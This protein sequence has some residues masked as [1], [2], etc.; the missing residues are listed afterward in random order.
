[1]E[2]SALNSQEFIDSFVAIEMHL[3]TLVGGSY[4]P[5]HQ[6]VFEAGKLNKIVRYYELELNEYAQLR[7]A[8]THTRTGQ[9]KIIAEP[10]DDVVKDIKK[11]QHAISEVKRILDVFTSGVYSVDV[12]DDLKSVLKYKHEHGYSVLPVY[13]EGVY[14]SMIHAD[15]YM[16]ATEVGL[17]KSEFETIGDLIAYSD[18]KDRVVFLPI[19]ASLVDALSVFNEQQIKGTKLIALIIT[20]SGYTNQKPLGILTVKDLPKVLSNLNK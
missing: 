7:N 8:I 12:N 9:S 10:H 11:I 14:H 19:N 18:P 4:M 6:L 13:R 2:S 20:E 3:R 17:G 16:R 15:L 1:M 5:F